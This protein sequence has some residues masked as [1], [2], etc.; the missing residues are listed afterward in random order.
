M[1]SLFVEP[2]CIVSNRYI[3]ILIAKLFYPNK[4]YPIAIEQSLAI[5]KSAVLKKYRTLMPS[6]DILPQEKEE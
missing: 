6:Y 2:F 3:E 5:K 1:E 4:T